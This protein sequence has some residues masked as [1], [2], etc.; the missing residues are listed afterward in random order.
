MPAMRQRAQRAA[1][2]ASLSAWPLLTL[3]LPTHATTAHL[4]ATAQT[5]IQVEHTAGKVEPSR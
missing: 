4:P 2:I 5:P 3:P 1:L